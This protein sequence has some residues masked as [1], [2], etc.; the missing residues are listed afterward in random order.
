MAKLQSEK[1]KTYTFKYVYA[2]LNN[3][4]MKKNHSPVTRQK[5][6]TVRIFIQTVS[7]DEVL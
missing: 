1:K 5:K 3:K 7:I 4:P 2:G 6:K